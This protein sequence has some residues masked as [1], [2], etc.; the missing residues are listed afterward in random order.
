MTRVRR[1]ETGTGQSPQI[2]VYP[3]VLALFQNRDALSQD[4]LERQEILILSN[5]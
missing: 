3:T 5:P 2:S 4:I 1:A